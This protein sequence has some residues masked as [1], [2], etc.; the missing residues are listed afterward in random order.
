MY[1]V[2][3]FG[4]VD[5]EPEL[6]GQQK[7][8]LKPYLLQTAPSGMN[9][10]A[11]VFG[12]KVALLGY[13]VSP[14]NIK[15]GETFEITWIWKANKAPGAGW[16][17]FTHVGD[18]NQ[19]ER[20]NQ[21]GF[22]GGPGKSVV[23]QHYQPG[24]WK[25]GEIIRDVQSITL[26]EDWNAR[27]VEFYLGL[28]KGEERMS[29]K[30]GT[31]DNGRAKVVTLNVGTATPQV[32]EP[33]HYSVLHTQ[34][35]LNIDGKLD[36][37]DWL[38]AK[39]T[40]FFVDTMNGKHAMPQAKAKMLWD[41]ANLYIAFE[42][43]DAYLRN[44][45]TKRDGTFDDSWFGSNTKHMWD[46]DVVEIMLD[47][48]GDSKDYFEIQVSPT[49]TVFDTRYDA[50][51]VPMDPAKELWGHMDWNPKM[52]VKTSVRGAAND[53]EKDEGY[54]VELKLPFS[55]IKTWAHAPAAGA[56]W[57]INLYAMDLKEDKGQVASGWSDNRVSDFHAQARFG[58]IHFEAVPA[59]APTAEA[60]T[61]EGGA[62]APTAGNE[63]SKPLGE[64]PN[65]QLIPTLSNPAA[66]FRLEDMRMLREAARPGVPASG[67]TGTAVKPKQ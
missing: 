6:T 25:T 19:K 54:T 49:G 55:S 29:I 8:A 30:G 27:T 63:S 18:E 17:L 51:R 22:N 20:L 62:Q 64:A 42:V 34:G 39:E 58:F 16:K 12:D 36:E 66:R 67:A 9:S 32:L 48:E 13:E 31:V 45:I 65:I 44:P 41:E 52:E 33:P 1:A 2:L 14:A 43:E 21:D 15:P 4:C 60:A 57:R 11:F 61:V 24:R 26:P 40:R 37:S 10:S 35:E 47:P 46:Y 28:W 59:P 5:R 7:S 53:D 50:Q 38:R 56:V 3:V 23:R